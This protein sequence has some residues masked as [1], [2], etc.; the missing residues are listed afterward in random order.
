[1]KISARPNRKEEDE[2]KTKMNLLFS[3]SQDSFLAGNMGWKEILWPDISVDVFISPPFSD[4]MIYVWLSRILA[5][6]PVQSG[7]LPQR[8]F[9]LHVFKHFLP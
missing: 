3:S 9:Y 6:C 8:Y 7:I 1:M 5:H 4:R 2:E